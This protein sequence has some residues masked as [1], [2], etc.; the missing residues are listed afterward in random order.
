MNELPIA[1]YHGCGNDFLL[2]H[3]ADVA[4]L[5]L[6]PLIVSAC[7]RHTGIGADGLIVAHPDP[8]EMQ[9][10]NADGS[11][12]PMCGNGIRCFAKFCLDEGLADGDLFPVQTAAGEKDVRVIRRD[13][14]LAQVRMGTPDYSPAA[15]RALSP[16]PMWEYELLAG[17]RTV[18]LYSFFLSTVHTVWFVDDALD[19]ALLPTAEEIHR[20][21]V[22]QEKTNV[23]LVQVIDWHTIRMRTWERGAG[24][25]LACGTGACAGALT[26]LKKGF[27]GP[28]VD[29]LLPKGQLHISI[30]PEEA[31]QM[32]GPAC[33]IMK[34]AYCYD[35]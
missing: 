28:E 7:D 32:T 19:D 14:F 26:A 35:R 34:G 25:T 22:F 15:I 5:D 10:Y 20:N 4:D 12:A 16:R 2:V 29:V 31:V 21:P 11:A 13:P 17:G 33:R 27:C 3:A 30:S 6:K 8:L 1:K 23:D 9:F 24:L 18:T